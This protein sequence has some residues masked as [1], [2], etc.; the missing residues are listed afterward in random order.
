WRYAWD[1]LL[2]DRLSLKQICEE[3][4]GRGYSLRTGVPFVMVKPDGRRVS[5]VKALSRAFHNWFYA[6]WVVIDTEWA[7]IAPKSVRGTW[8]PVVSTEEFEAGLTILDK[9]NQDR[10]HHKKHFYLL[11]GLIHLQQRDRSIVKLTCSMPNANR[12]RGGVAYY[13]IPSSKINFLC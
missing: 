11:Q 12:D 4:H 2:Q 1:L 3:L 5:N 10:S 8:K 13:C 6:G 7:N 9:R